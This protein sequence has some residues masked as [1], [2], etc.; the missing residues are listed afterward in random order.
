M[1]SARMTARNIL[2]TDLARANA[3][4]T[5]GPS[6][7]LESLKSGDFSGL[8]GVRR[9]KIGLSQLSTLPY[10]IFADLPRADR[11]QYEI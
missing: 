3:I 7:A 9:V 4:D 11:D 1:V 5:T 10:G 2:D 6:L 8:T